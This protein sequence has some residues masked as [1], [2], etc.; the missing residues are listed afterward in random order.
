MKKKTFIAILIML[1]VVV[2]VAIKDIIFFIK[3]T[4]A[5]ARHVGIDRYIIHII[6]SVLNLAVLTIAVIIAV[7]VIKQ[8][9][10]QHDAEYKQ[11]QIEREEAKKQ[12]ERSKIE[13]EIAIL[14]EQIE[15]KKKRIE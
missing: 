1:T 10:A 15:D 12:K 14:Q 9:R 11:R 13:E 5:Y 7:I 8:Y 6:S 2:G 3:Q 4:I